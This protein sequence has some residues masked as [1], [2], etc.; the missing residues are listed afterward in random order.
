MQNITTLI[1]D[2]GGVIECSSEQRNLLDVL[3]EAL[4]LD[5]AAVYELYFQRNHLHNTGAQTSEQT[6]LSVIETLL[7]DSLE[8]LSTASDIIQQH[9]A[10]SF[11]NTPLL[12]YISELKQHGYTVALL[13]NYGAHLR[14]KIQGTE[15]AALFGEHIFLSGEI[16]LQKP[17]PAI[18]LHTFDTLG[19]DPSAVAFIDDSQ[20]SLSTA[21]EV[22]YTPILYTNN[23]ELF[24]HLRE[25]GVTL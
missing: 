21:A 7:P 23:T 25:L 17:D 9:K 13:S 15:V 8:A 16:G 18:F 12:K 3:S 10:A 22:G 6:L 11:I 20:K 4:S 19:V 1:F 14:E 24:A 5:P 2:Y